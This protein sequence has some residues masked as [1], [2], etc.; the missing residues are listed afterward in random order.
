VPTRSVIAKS[1]ILSSGKRATSPVVAERRTRLFRNCCS[2]RSRPIHKRT[3]RL[4]FKVSRG[5]AVVELRT[6]PTRS[7]SVV[8]CKRLEQ[9]TAGPR[10]FTESGW[11]P[12]IRAAQGS[13]A[14]SCSV[15]HY[16]SIHECAARARSCTKPRNC[17]TIR[18]SCTRLPQTRDVCR[19]GPLG[20]RS[21]HS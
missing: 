2:C 19:C 5:P 21:A 9:R 7:R 1:P 13:V 15:A 6:S 10:S 3:A 12:A 17:L 8:H 4:P 14:S 16:G 18:E 20:K 11:C